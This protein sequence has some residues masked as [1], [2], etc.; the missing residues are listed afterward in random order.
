[1]VGL[2]VIFM[3][4]AIS[5]NVLAYINFGHDGC[6]SSLWLNVAVSVLI[7][8]MPI[9]QII[10]LNPQNNLLTT[11]LVAL[12]V[13]YFSYSAQL[14]IGGE[15]RERLKLGTYV[16]DVSVNMFLFILTTYGTISGGLSEEPEIERVGSEAE[17]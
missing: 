7:F 4:S 15:C 10:R 6:G 3:G 1:M 8:L 9:V 17:Q 2:S 11:S 5:L 16:A 13:S 12:L 14:S